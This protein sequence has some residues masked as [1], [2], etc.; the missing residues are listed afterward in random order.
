MRLFADS[1]TIEAPSSVP[2]NRRE[3]VRS[4]PVVSAPPIN[5]KGRVIVTWMALAV[6]SYFAL[7]QVSRWP[8]RLRYPGE[9]DAAE[10]TQL[11]E[12]VHLRQGVQ[13]YRVPSQ[14]EFDSAIYGPLSYLLGAALID[15]DKPAYL[16]LR[17]LSLAAT[18]GL[19]AVVAVFVFKLTRQKL[20]GAMAALL[21]LS[22]AFVGRYGVSAR[23]DM[24]AL[25]LAFSGFVVFY[26][27]R[28]SRRALIFSVGLLLLSFF[29]KQQFVGAPVAVFL[30]LIAARRFRYAL[31]FV[32]MMAAGG[33]ALVLLFSWLIFPH[34]AFLLHFIIYNRL[35]FEKGYLLPEILMFAIPLFVPLLGAADYV[36]NNPDKLVACYAGTSV[37]AYF[38]LLSS[39]GSGADTNRCLEAALVLTCLFAA[40]IVTTKRMLGGVAWTAALAITLTLVSLLSSAFVVRKITSSD[41]AADSALQNYL[42]ENFPAR[43]SV[44]SYYAGDPL[45]AGLSAPIT[46][47]WHYSA[48]IRKGALSDRDIVSRIDGGGYGAILLDFDLAHFDSGH[49]ADFY[50]TPSVR[51]AILRGYR[52]ISRLNMPSP[53]L[54]RHA[55]GNI[56]VWIPN[57]ADSPE[58]TIGTRGRN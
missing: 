25:L 20:G 8:D 50:T 35:P 54:T 17:L 47:L 6:V 34:Q 30:S 23:A 41:F 22:T 24:V 58:T 31:E 7:G 42:K 16:P 3:G 2:F 53:E 57:V 10:G 40:R 14:G 56:Y 51:H 15:P 26:S 28:E 18:L 5:T 4:G 21:L 9:E 37:A 27:N 39:S 19:A 32:A 52:Q 55:D 12:M 13:I 43:T 48:L 11:S 33:A 38:A 45:R 1:G 44:L 46:N 49:M 29:Y 36:D